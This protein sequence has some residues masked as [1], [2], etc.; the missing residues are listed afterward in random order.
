MRTVRRALGVPVLGTLLTKG[1]RNH[2]RFH[3]LNKR[4][5]VAVRA[6][7]VSGLMREHGLRWAAPQG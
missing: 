3:I 4:R 2:V 7:A 6:V 1:L 5:R